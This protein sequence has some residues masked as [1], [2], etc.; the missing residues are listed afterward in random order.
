MC[1]NVILDLEFCSIKK[2][3]SKGLQYM[4]NEVIQ[5]G[6]VMLDDSM[7]IVD[8]FM[9]Y[10]KPEYTTITKNITSLT[11]IASEDLKEAPYFAKVL[12]KFLDWMGKE[13]EDTYIYSWSDVD[14]YQ[15]RDEA[16]E[17]GIIDPRLDIVF[18]HWN[19]FQ[20]E[21]GAKIGYS[22]QP[23]SLLNALASVDFIFE[24]KQHNAI[25]DARN[26]AKL[27]ALC[28]D[29]EKFESKTKAIRSCFIEDE[30]SRVTIGDM[31]SKDLEMF[32]CC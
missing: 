12:D 31:F 9:C 20:K 30:R 21:F 23:I 2:K 17:K 24:G 4:S 15:I 10:V 11:G 8:E 19:D 27:F 32:I 18:S 16:R 28:E 6:A 25:N 7:Q 26:T 1:K 3:S 29:K 13:I 5:F 22:A 14:E